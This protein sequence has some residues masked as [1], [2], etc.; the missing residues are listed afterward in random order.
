L[1]EGDGERMTGFSTPANASPVVSSSRA[2]SDHRYQLLCDSVHGLR[3][4]RHRRAGRCALLRARRRLL[5]DSLDLGQ[6]ARDV[7]NAAGLLAAR[8]AHFINQALDFD[9]AIRDAANRLRQLVAPE[10]TYR[11]S[12][13]GF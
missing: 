10:P 11:E 7:V 4:C 9:R 13:V 3:L 12:P 6:R 5:S 8:N 1:D 2:F